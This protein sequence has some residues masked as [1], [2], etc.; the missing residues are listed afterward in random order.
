MQVHKN[1]ENLN[2]PYVKPCFE[3]EIIGAHFFIRITFI[4]IEAQIGRKIK[5]ML[6]IF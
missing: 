6:K 4:R 5:N 3:P 1:N 2:V